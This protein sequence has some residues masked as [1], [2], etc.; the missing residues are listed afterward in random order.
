MGQR[1]VKMPLL[2]INEVNFIDQAGLKVITSSQITKDLVGEKAYG[3][4]CI[5]NN[6]TL[7]YLVISSDFIK[8]GGLEL[9]KWQFIIRKSVD[10]ILE[11]NDNIKYS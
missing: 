5:P 11:N 1:K 6:W 9:E 8:C 3:L 10:A 4:S 7:P 2:P